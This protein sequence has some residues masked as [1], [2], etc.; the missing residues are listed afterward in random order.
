[1]IYHCWEEDYNLSTS[2]RDLPIDQHR[3]KSAKLTQRVMD[4]R[5]W[6]E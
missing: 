4:I 5:I 1:M 2:V 6:I 3:L